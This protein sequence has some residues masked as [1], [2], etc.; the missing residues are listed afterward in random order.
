MS[1]GIRFLVRVRVKSL[2]DIRVRVRVRVRNRF[3][4]TLLCDGGLELF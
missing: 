1:P 3:R 2:S 4:C